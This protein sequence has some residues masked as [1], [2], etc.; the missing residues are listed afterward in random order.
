[1][2]HCVEVHVIFTRIF[3]QQF[4]S[5]IFSLAYRNTSE[6]LTVQKKKSRKPSSILNIISLFHFTFLSK[7]ATLKA[8]I[9]SWKCTKY[10]PSRT[11]TFIWSIERVKY[12][13]SIQYI[14]FVKP[15]ELVACIDF[16]RK[17]PLRS[18]TARR[19]CPQTPSAAPAECSRWLP[20]RIQSFKNK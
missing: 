12:I 1:M 13:D 16:E 17:L 18:Q 11:V 15:F 8:A 3:S 14:Q 9:T 19:V 2:L 4:Q 7:C 5:S 20:G 10:F 6:D